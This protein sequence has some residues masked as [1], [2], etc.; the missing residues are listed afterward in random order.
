[1]CTD[2]CVGIYSPAAD[3]CTDC[4][5]GIYSPAAGMCADCC[6]GIYSPAA[7]MCADC[8]V[9]IYSSVADVCA[10]CCVGI[11]SPAA[12]MCTDCCVGIYSPAAGMCADC[13]GI[14]GCSCPG[15]V[16]CKFEFP[17][18]LS[19]SEFILFINSMA[20]PGVRFARNTFIPES[21][22]ARAAAFPAPPAPITSAFLFLSSANFRTVSRFRVPH[23]SRI[24]IS[25]E[26]SCF[27]VFFTP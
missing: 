21:F 20:L 19:S 9:G 11:Y 26:T 12:G 10:D 22:R 18:V 2:C 4:C 8:C 16:L 24:P 7:G 13:R 25:P 5:V 3:V 17:E 27:M 23:F 1:M 6:V 15:R 14:A